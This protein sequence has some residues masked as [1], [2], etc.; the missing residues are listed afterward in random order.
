MSVQEENK[1]ILRHK[2]VEELFNKGN[3]AVADEIISP[4]YVYHGAAGETKGP[5]GVKQ[6]VTTLRTAFPDV[7]FTIDDM[8]AEGDNVAVRYTWTGTHRGEYMGISPTGKQMSVTMAGFYRF[9]GGKE[10][11]VVTYVDMLNFYQQ[12][13]VVPTPGQ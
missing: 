12:L 11:D 6:M 4:D 13:G 3:S 2:H 5:E 7:H 10:L 9:A 8:V 1:A